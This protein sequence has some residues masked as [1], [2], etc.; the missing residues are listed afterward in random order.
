ML[1][2]IM[3]VK[4]FYHDSCK[5]CDQFQAEINLWLAENSIEVISTNRTPNTYTI[6]YKERKETNE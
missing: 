4:I 6:L 3:K 1:F 5:L 2:S